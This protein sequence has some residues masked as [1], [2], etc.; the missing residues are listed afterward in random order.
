[1]PDSLEPSLAID[2]ALSM[3]ETPPALH[4]NGIKDRIDALRTELLKAQYEHLQK[5]DQALLI[6]IAGID[7][8]GKGETIQVLNEWMDARH[9]ATLAFGPPSPQAAVMPRLWRYWQHLPARGQ[10]GIVFGSW[11][12]PLFDELAK[13]KP[14]TATVQALAREVREFESLLTHNG[15]QVVKLWFHMSAEAQAK[16]V[17][18]LLANPDTAWRVTPLD[19]KVRKKFPRARRAGALAMTLTDSPLS[20]W[21]VVASENEHYR[22]LQ[23]GETVLKAMQRQVADALPDVPASPVQAVDTPPPSLDTVDYGADLSKADYEPLLVQWQAR[24][25]RL[26][27]HRRFA[28]IPLILVF[29]GQDAAGKGGAIRRLTHALDP[30][31]F[32][33]IPIAAPSDEELARPYLWRFWRRLPRPGNIAIFDRSWYGRVL[34]ERVEGYATEAQWRRA[35]EEINQFEAQLPENGAIVL[36]FWLAITKDEQLERFEDR[37]KSP[38]KSFKIT[39]EDWRNREKWDAY[40]EAT[41]DMF[42]LTHTERFPWHVISANDKHHARIE[43]LKTVVN[44]LEAALG[45]SP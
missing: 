13:K 11:Y 14:D 5:K 23:V 1:M 12:Q 15:V 33:A 41:N 44:A 7:G 21:V 39:P 18:T 4:K 6:V 17:D 30:R 3:A 10:T 40:V 2:A 8:V 25:A 42:R 19:V 38:F 31:Q 22:H 43:V 28:D 29:E 16:H 35:Y 36:K 45:E 27:R 37:G 32:R 9:I 24:L 20:P 34:V 26:V